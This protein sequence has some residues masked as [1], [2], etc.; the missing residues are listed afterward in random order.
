MLHTTT[1]EAKKN[2]VLQIKFLA[3]VGSNKPYKLF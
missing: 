2:L 3:I 1:N